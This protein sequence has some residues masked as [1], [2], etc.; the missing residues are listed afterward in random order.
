MKSAAQ[1][2]LALLILVAASGILDAGQAPSRRIRNPHEI[3]RELAV[4]PA[5]VG[6]VKDVFPA[7]LDY[8]DMVMFHP[9]FG[10]YSSGR[11]SFSDDYQTFPI[12]L[13]PAFGNMIAE[14]LF[15]MWDGMRQ[16]GTL[17]REGHVHDRR[18]RRR[19]RRAGRI[20]PRVHPGAGRRTSSDGRSSRGRRCMSATTD[21]RRS[22]RCR[23]SATARSAHASTGASPTP[24]T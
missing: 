8:H 21:R 7:F 11:V 14:H 3:Y 15:Q 16:A 2:F 12:V 13:A 18:V 22:T 10:Y 17:G 6:R 1:R 23:R 4:D 24:P 9:K 5:S 20:D 19:Q